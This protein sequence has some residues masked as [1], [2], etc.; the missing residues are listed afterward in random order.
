MEETIMTLICVP[1]LDK[2]GLQ[3]KISQHLGK[4]PYFVLINWENDQIKNFQILESKGKHMGGQMT[5]GEFIVG[6][7]ANI[8]LCGNLGSK[9]IQMFQKAGIE[10]FVGASGTVIE[11]LQ[12]WTEE[13]LKYANIDSACTNGHI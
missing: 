7:G 8:L 5:P 2:D 4:T 3:G 13:K 6:S 12:D 10:V 9:A 1:S 11:A